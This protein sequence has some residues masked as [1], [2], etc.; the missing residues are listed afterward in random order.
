MQ[1]V[2]STAT[3]RNAA[4][5]VLLGALSPVDRWMLDGRIVSCCKVADVLFFRSAIFSSAPEALHS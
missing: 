5:G 3:R 2:L 4:S 1:T